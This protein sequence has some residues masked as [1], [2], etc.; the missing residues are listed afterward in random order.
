MKETLNAHKSSVTE[1][2]GITIPKMAEESELFTSE[3]NKFQNFRAATEEA[4][5]SM[6]DLR[7]LN[8]YGNQLKQT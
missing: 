1:L 5:T 8:N 3:R 4:I 2:R 7:C 6:A